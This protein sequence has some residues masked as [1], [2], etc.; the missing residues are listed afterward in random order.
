MIGSSFYKLCLIASLFPPRLSRGAGVI[1]MPS[2]APR[3]HF[4]KFLTRGKP[5]ERQSL[6]AQVISAR[7]EPAISSGFSTAT[8][9]LLSAARNPPLTIRN[10]AKG[11]SDV[12]WVGRR[13]AVAKKRS[14][15]KI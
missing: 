5:S 13:S 8:S 12:S 1:L 3:A 9:A 15:S 14:R 7:F 10:T 4:K 11:P 2:V 6:G